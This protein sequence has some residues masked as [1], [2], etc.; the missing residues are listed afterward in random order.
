MFCK[1][2]GTE[3]PEGSRFC[4]ACGERLEG[5]LRSRGT[6]SAATP[7]AAAVSSEKKGSTGK[8]ISIV[9]VVLVVVIIAL[10]QFHVCDFCEET[11]WGPG[12]DNAEYDVHICNDCAESYHWLG[13]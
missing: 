5:T 4:A 3:L 7:A 6:A 11:F 1:T 8:V 2:C 10:T 13:I 12:Y 9:A